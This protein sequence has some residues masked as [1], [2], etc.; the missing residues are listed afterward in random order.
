M[1]KREPQAQNA[2]MPQFGVIE[3]G[4]LAGWRFAFL[5]FL[6]IDGALYLDLRCTPPDWP[7]PQTVRFSMKKDRFTL[8][9]VEGERARRH[10]A[11]ALIAQ[12]I[13]HG[14]SYSPLEE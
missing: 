3:R 10:D 5:R 2:H 12:A 1:A 11:L 4:P 7:F 13:E 8:R 9:A 6:Q 14:A